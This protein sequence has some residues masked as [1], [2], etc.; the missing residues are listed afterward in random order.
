MFCVLDIESSGGPFGKEAM[1]EIAAFRYDGSE[2]VDQLISLVHPH[3]KVQPFVAKMTGITDKML[4]RA[5]RFQ[6]IAKR[7]IE[8]TEDAIIVGHNVE[9][10]Y[11][12]LRQEFARL[13]YH[14]ERKT[15]DTIKLAEELLPGMPA[16]GLDKLC[17]ELGLYRS[18]K[19]RA[20]SDA[21]AT[22][23]LFQILQEKD[24]RK[25]INITEQS[26]HSRDF[27]K[28]KVLDLQRSLKQNKGLFYLHNKEGNLLYLGASDNVKAALNR[29]F[30]SESEQAESLRQQVHGIKVEACGNWL[31]ARI[32]R[33]LELAQ[34][35][36]PFNRLPWEKL[37][38]GLYL[39][40]REKPPRLQILALAEAGKKKPLLKVHNRR[41]GRRALRMY[42]RLPAEQKLS[43]A[44][45]L[46]DFPA[47][48]LYLAKGRKHGEVCVF[49]TKEG[50]LRGYFYT[51]MRQLLHNPRQIA[52]HLG[53]SQ[54]L[55]EDFDALLK[56]GIISGE[57]KYYQSEKLED[58]EA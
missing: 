27:M 12:M 32:R 3:R 41:A 57:F 26:I 51:Q 46:L 24:L 43:L 11:R 44:Q 22:L 20:E 13:G 28:D 47:E 17:D 49:V 55:G 2:V 25:G 35:R 30:M 39:D 18:Q 10:D 52:A 21:R 14:F 50:Q 33:S 6:E 42:G 7:L 37:S 34:S 19:H 40:Q 38:Y 4:V 56:L 36:P 9:F 31:V 54:A 1:I 48:G 8:I 16:Y 5:P 45:H 23:E 15:L 58:S 53:T 29:L